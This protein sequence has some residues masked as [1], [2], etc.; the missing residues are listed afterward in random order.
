M[1]VSCWCSHPRVSSKHSEPEL[2]MLLKE[3]L[4]ILCVPC[5][6]I[7]E[8]RKVLGISKR[9]AEMLIK[10][11]TGVTV[12]PLQTDLSSVGSPDMSK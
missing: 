8:M 2:S 9:D 6:V 12:C 7:M 4:Q 5:E 3:I 10:E 11:D 1:E